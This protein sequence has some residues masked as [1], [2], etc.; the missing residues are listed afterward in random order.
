MAFLQ[1]V[2]EIIHLSLY[3]MDLFNEYHIKI[4]FPCWTTL[5]L[6][7]SPFVQFQSTISS[8]PNTISL[9]HYN[10]QSRWHFV[11]QIKLYQSTC[12][13]IIDSPLSILNHSDTTNTTP[14]YPRCNFPYF[15]TG[16]GMKQSHIIT[17]NIEKSPFIAVLRVWSSSAVLMFWIQIHC[18]V[19]TGTHHIRSS[20]TSL[21]RQFAVFENVV[22]H[23]LTWL[24]S[25][26]K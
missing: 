24:A 13:H 25:G 16:H 19:Q 3:G 11:S 4:H 7:I 21:D 15:V 18:I 22:V 9:C 6:A 17:A 2:I 26:S 20:R 8:N 12:T 5:S 23:G 14:I 10:T 1:H